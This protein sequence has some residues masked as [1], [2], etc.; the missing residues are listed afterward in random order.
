MTVLIRADAVIGEGLF[1]SVA[2]AAEVHLK[3]QIGSIYKT[4]ILYG[5]EDS[6]DRI[7]FYEQAEL[8]VRKNPPFAIKQKPTLVW[9]PEG[10]L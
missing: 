8:T 5:S 9:R 2:W 7:E 1:D 6:P 4:A 3:R 10:T